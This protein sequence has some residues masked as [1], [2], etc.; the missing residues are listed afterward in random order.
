M[1]DIVHASIVAQDDMEII[2]T[3][4]M[5]SSAALPGFLSEPDVVVLGLPS[6]D[7]PKEWEAALYEHPHLKLLAITMDGRRAFLHE[8]APRATPLG[9]VSPELLLDAIRRAGLA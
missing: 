3:S 7:L 9:E 8:L 1:S 2:E 5:P 4:A 6:A